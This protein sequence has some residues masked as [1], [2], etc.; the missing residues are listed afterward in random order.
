MNRLRTR[1]TAW[2]IALLMVLSLSGVAGASALISFKQPATHVAQTS[3]EDEDGDEQGE[4]AEEQVDEDADEDANEAPEADEQDVEDQDSEDAAKLPTAEDLAECATETLTEEDLVQRDG[5]S[6]GEYVS[7]IAHSDATGGPN[8]NHGFCVSAAARGLFEALA[9]E[10][11]ETPP[12]T[13][14]PET[15]CNGWLEQPPAEGTGHGEFVSQVAK[16]KE[17]VGG[18]HNNHGY[19]VSRAARG[20]FNNEGTEETSDSECGTTEQPTDVEDEDVDDATAS[21]HGKAEKAKDKAEK[22]KDKAEKKAEK[23]KK[24]KF[25]HGKR[26][27]KG[28]RP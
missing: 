27:G 7:R 15:E 1:W 5:E 28:H 24:A 9:E 22:A 18:P 23:A 17:A 12:T 21:C 20:D 14:Q 4:N 25:E 2:P 6:H 11:E 26:R 16:D 8:D 10:D 13:E 19:C 3:E